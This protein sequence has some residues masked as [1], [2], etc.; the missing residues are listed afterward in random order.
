LSILGCGSDLVQSHHQHNLA[1]LLQ[2]A[3]YIPEMLDQIGCPI[4]SA[5]RA[6]TDK[7][8]TVTRRMWLRGWHAL[9]KAL[10][11]GFWLRNLNLPVILDALIRVVE[12]L[13]VRIYHD[14]TLLKKGRADLIHNGRAI[15]Q[16]AFMRASKL[17]DISGRG[18]GRLGGVD[19]NT[20]S[21]T[22]DTN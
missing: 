8:H 14:K 19:L 17:C 15:D 1:S 9:A 10:P 20:V 6:H 5:N 13:V 12:L 18:L 7:G 22:A 16:H 2:Q 21:I 3:R 11:N 4:G